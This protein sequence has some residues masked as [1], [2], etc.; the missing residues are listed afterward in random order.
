MSNAD[1]HMK[2]EK[3]SDIGQLLQVIGGIITFIGFILLFTSV[4]IGVGIL[5]LGLIILM[6]AHIFFVLD[7]IN[8]RLFENNFIL[9]SERDEMIDNEGEDV[10]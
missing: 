7:T 10:G 4:P 6:V 8:R 3:K 2:V 9:Q 5:A 1:V